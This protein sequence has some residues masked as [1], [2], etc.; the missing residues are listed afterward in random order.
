MAALVE[1]HRPQTALAPHCVVDSDEHGGETNERATTELVE[2]LDGQLLRDI[3]VQA[4]L[5]D[6]LLPLGVGRQVEEQANDG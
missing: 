4:V 1:Q 3:E 6:I 5:A 2:A